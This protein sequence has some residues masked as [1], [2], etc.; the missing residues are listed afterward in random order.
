ME[1]NK[2]K[3]E[4]QAQEAVQVSYKEK[5]VNPLCPPR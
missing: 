2:N 1:E 4:L 5:T 3:S